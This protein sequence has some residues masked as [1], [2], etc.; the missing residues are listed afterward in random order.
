MN[1]KI[2]VVDDEEQ[3]QAGLKRYLE[4]SGFGE[5][6]VAG[7]VEAAL[8]IW[9]RES[10]H[11]VIADLGLPGRSGM[12]LLEE[13][14]KHSPATQV[15]LITGMSSLDRALDGLERGA[16]DYLMKPLDMA[17]VERMVTECLARYQRWYEVIKVNLRKRREKS[18]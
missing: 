5:V 9:H 7:D 14:K 4:Y 15:I 13:I 8:A 17:L 6:L 18:A 12:V 11:V 3:I 10:P 16:I 2:L 1:P